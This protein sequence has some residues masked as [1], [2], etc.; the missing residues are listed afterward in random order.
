M[1]E[2]AAPA[3]AP[4][5]GAVGRPGLGGIDKAGGAA[6]RVSG[7]LRCTVAAMVTLEGIAGVRSRVGQELGVSEWYDV[8]QDVI[9]TFAECT[10]D[11]QWI[12]VDR[13][14]A[15]A[16]TFGGTIAH[17]LFT[18]SLGPKFAGE[19]FSVE[20]FAFGLNYGYDR[21]RYPAPLP[22]G[23]RVRMRAELSSA[24]DVPGGVQ[25]VVRQTFEREGSEK[26]VCVADAISRWIV[27]A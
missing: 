22:V 19:L 4:G 18:L 25:I 21:V 7:P 17:G 24:E 15:S 12:H 20:G 16:S 27:D 13:Q 23:S 9:D 1:T 5:A 2:P 26:P 3:A 14:R 11:F 6:R 8:S 10:G